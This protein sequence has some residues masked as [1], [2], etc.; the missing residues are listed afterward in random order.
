MFWD[1]TC[2]VQACI[3]CYKEIYNS[4]LINPDTRSHVSAIYTINAH[5]NFTDY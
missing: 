2:D 1:H 5:I 4:A 3:Y